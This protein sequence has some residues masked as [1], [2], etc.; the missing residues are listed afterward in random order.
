MDADSACEADLPDLAEDQKTYGGVGG[1]LS[2]ANGAHHVRLEIVI[3]N[4]CAKFNSKGFSS[5]KSKT[6][7]KEVVIRRIS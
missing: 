1:V 7:T 5:S 2:D 4:T 6:T 3:N